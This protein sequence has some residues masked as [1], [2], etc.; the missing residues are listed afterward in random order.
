MLIVLAALAEL[1]ELAVSASTEKAAW[2]KRCE[3]KG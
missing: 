1:A 3:F 2:I